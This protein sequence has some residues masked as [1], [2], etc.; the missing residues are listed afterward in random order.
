M[1][2][3]QGNLYVVEKLSEMLANI[4]AE[5]A[6]HVPNEATKNDVLLYASVV[7]SF[8]VKDAELIAFSAHIQEL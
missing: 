7:L 4:P 5:L 1:S 6:I 3:G 2:F 8:G